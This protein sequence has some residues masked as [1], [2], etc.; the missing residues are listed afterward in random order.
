M[1]FSCILARID[2]KNDNE[3]S[4]GETTMKTI[5]LSR[6]TATLAVLGAAAAL[7]APIAAHPALAQGPQGGFGGPG[8]GGRGGFG[9]QGGFNRR[10]PVAYGT[11][12]A[13]DTGAGTITISGRGGGADQTIQTQGTTQIVSQVAASVSDLKKGDMIQVQGVPTGITASSLSIGQS[14]LAGL[15]G[16]GGGG[17]GGPGG[18]PPPGGGTGAAAAPAT[19]SATGTVTGTSPLTISLSSTA[20]LTLKM[21]PNAKVT[22]YMP[23]TVSTIKVGD[24]VLAI[25]TANDDGSFAATTV[26]LNLDMST[27]GGFGG[28]GGGFGGRGGGFG[29]RGG[30]G[31]GGGGGFGGPGGGGG[32]GGPGGG[33][34]GGM[35]PNGFG[36][37]GGPGAPPPPQ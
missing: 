13:V 34:P 16:P 2:I 7:L 37:P 11:V 23:V 5:Q 9:G 22:K 35:P 33:G 14:P 19:A 6:K 27:L 25:G 24:R 15:G 20:S 12:T 30:G 36:G 3:T 18:P 28:R 1:W 8:G 32:F 10:P 31:R 4:T 17:F 29:G 26:A 21:D